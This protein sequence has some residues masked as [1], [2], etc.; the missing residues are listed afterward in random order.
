MLASLTY[1]RED[2]TFVGVVGGYPYHVIPSDP[3]WPEAVAMA[4]EM[5]D[6]LPFEPPP[7]EPVPPPLPPVSGRQFKAALAIAGIITEA[8]MVSPDLP[9]IVAPALASMTTP[10]RIIARATWANLS[11][12]EGNEELLA[13]FAAVH[14]PPLGPDDIAA[15]MAAARAIP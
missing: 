7:P 6:A 12:V 5:G 13:V 15:L 1:R 2:G 8:E 3:L 14:Q 10:Q 11:R 9:A 4:A